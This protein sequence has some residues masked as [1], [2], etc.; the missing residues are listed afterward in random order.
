MPQPLVS[1]HRRLDPNGNLQISPSVARKRRD[2]DRVS[3]DVVGPCSTEMHLAEI[4]LILLRDRYW[5]II[6]PDQAPT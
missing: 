1:S 6:A 2:D 5:I 3:A 4:A